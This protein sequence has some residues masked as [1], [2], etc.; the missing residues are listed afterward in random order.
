[1]TYIGID[2]GLSG[3]IAWIR[4]GH[5]CAEKMP[6]TDRD[7]L[8][9]LRGL[10]REEALGMIYCALEKVHSMPKQGVTSTF[11]FGEHFGKLQMALAALEI[12][13]EFVTPQRWQKAI[14]CLTGGD[15][16]VSKAAA[17]RM[18]PQVHKITH[19]TA[20]ALLI[21][22]FCKSTANT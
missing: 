19:A 20:D 7:I 18:F 13:F 14:G 10:I 5:P 1:M 21:A 15:K 6:A 8:D 12:P 22:H 3:G 16:N 11:T 9:L 2:P 17:Q 4:D